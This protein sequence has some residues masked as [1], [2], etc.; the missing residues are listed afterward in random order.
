MVRNGTE[1]CFTSLEDAISTF[2]TWNWE[3]D[4]IIIRTSVMSLL[5]IISRHITFVSS[6]FRKVLTSRRRQGLWQGLRNTCQLNRVNQDRNWLILES[7]WQISTCQLYVCCHGMTTNTSYILLIY[8]QSMV[9]L[10]YR[11]KTIRLWNPWKKREIWTR[12]TQCRWD[13]PNH[14]IIYN[15]ATQ[16]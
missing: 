4:T 14:P 5:L 2:S 16:P 6:L 1:T 3:R 15:L 12:S 8:K 11:N 7:F 9:K 10:V 13:A